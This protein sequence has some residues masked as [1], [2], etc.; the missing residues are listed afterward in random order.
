M[1]VLQEGSTYKMWYVGHRISGQNTSKVGYATSSD[2]ITW[3]KYP[4][5]PVVNRTTQDQDISVVRTDSG[6]YY[7]YIEVNNSWIDLLTSTDGITWTAN[8]SNPVRTVAAS[9]VVW[10]EGTSWFMLYESMQTPVLDIYLATSP[11][12]LTWADS[13]SNP[14]LTGVDEVIPDSVI[15]DGSTYHLYYHRSDLAGF[16]VWHATSTNLTSWTNR[17]RLYFGYTSPTVVRRSDGR[18]LM[19]VWDLVGDGRYYL[20]YDGQLPVQYHWRFDDGAGGVAVESLRRGYNGVLQGPTWTAGRIGGALQFDG[21]NDG[22]LTSFARDMSAWTVAVWVRG[23]A[24]PGSASSSGPV[25]RGGAFQFNWNHP[26]P[27]FRGAAAVVVGGNWYPASFGVL[28]L[29]P[30]IT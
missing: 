26:D 28:P 12:G 23:N 9:P 25:H 1:W 21:V 6:I 27:Q 3:T 8:P 24:A 5:N 30:G 20:R 18:L 19:Y 11:D 10:R 14:V 17:E 16:P 15:K 22:V 4:G 29:E 2:G 7:M 13:A